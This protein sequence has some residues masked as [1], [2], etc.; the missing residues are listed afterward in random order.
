MRSPFKFLDAY[1]LQDRHAFFGREAETEAL[2]QMVFKTPLLL[3]YGISG[4][5]KTSLIQCGLA[6]KFDGPDWFPIFIR[7]QHNI[8]D[9]LQQALNEVLV[10]ADTEVPTSLSDKVSY[11]YRY[12]LRPV[13]LIFDQFEELFILGNQAEQQL[14]INDLSQLLARKLPCK[15]ILSMREEYIGQLYDFEKVIPTLFDFRLRLEPMNLLRVKAVMR[16]SFQQFN[17][18]LEAPEDERLDQMLDNLSAGKSGIQLPYLQ[19]YLDLLYKKDFAS[20]YHR[21]REGAELPMLT[22]T[23]AEIAELGRIENVLDLFLKEQESAIQQQLAQH[24]PELP[25]Q[26]VRQILDAF[27]T[28]EGTKRPVRFH[29]EQDNILLEEKVQEWLPQVPPQA[30]TECLEALERSRLVRFAG[31]N[32]ELA[33]DSLADLI[34]NQ[35]SD[36]QRQL[37]DIKRRIQYSYDEYLK[38]GDYL[39]RRQLSTFETYL[40]QLRL[41][42]AVQEFIEKSQAYVS[43]QEQAELERQR[44]ELE[45]TQ[46]KLAAE[47]RAK[48]R[49]RGYLIAV[50]IIA[51]IAFVSGIWAYQQRLEAEAANSNLKEQVLATVL[52]NAAAFRSE[53]KYEDA[54]LQV[55]SIRDLVQSP[56]GQPL[57]GLDSMLVRLQQVA[58]YAATADSLLAIPDSIPHWE[59]R[60]LT[61]LDIYKKANAIYTDANL[62]VKI[63]QVEHTIDRTFEDRKSRAVSILKFGGCDYA[64]PILQKANQLKPG[65]PEVLKMLRECGAQ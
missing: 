64:V 48:K 23:Q 44:R 25:P 14:F 40:P 52:A 35:R 16:Q 1:T 12:Y 38:S 4:T 21:E 39:S 33:H 34:D 55:K 61:A 41:D 47:Q 65:D 15:V 42:A 53:G 8:N 59:A 9:A 20:T 28:E 6:G 24:Y 46:Q 26:A 45:L 56:T 18:L 57:T 5:G 3:L 62:S 27:V 43:S 19:V 29:R 32:I 36:Q 37:N 58:T 17:I 30:L 49:Q 31:E 63:N 51:F 7:R 10:E 11:L 22:F 60:L 54:I 2:Y 13:Y 50:A